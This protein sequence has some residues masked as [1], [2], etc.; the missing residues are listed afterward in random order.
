M[1]D[2]LWPPA[3]R[4]S[5]VLFQIVSTSRSGGQSIEG[6]EQIVL[7][8]TGRWKARFTLPIADRRRGP[9]ADQVLAFRWVFSGGRASTIL[10]P[11]A[12]GRGPG[13]RAG[14]VPCGYHVPFSDGAF[15][16][17]GS[18]FGEKYTTAFFAADAALNATQVSINLTAGL[19]LL[20]G[21]RFSTPDGRLHEIRD[22]VSFDGGTI[23]T[24]TVSPWLRAAYPATVALEFDQPCCRMRLAA[25][26]SAA[27]S[28]MNNRFGSPS[29]EL[30][31]A[32]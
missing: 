21:M 5:E 2:R 32:N 11:A 12:D 24:V 25:D 23:W 13:H 7:A 18:G 10:V 28:L 20:P 15:F 14:I 30:V 27:L 4:G 6:N 29:L 26:D 8:P 3:L 17:D 16:S 22:V 31:E 9:R 1:A 19:Q